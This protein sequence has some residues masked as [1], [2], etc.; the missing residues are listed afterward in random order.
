MPNQSVICSIFFDD[1]KTVLTHGPTPE[2]PFCTTY[3]LPGIERGAQGSRYQY[4]K[5][6]GTWQWTGYPLSRK[7]FNLL[8]IPDMFE[9]EYRGSGKYGVNPVYADTS[10]FK[11]VPPNGG[12]AWS[13]VNQWATNRMSSG[14]ARI[15][16]F[17]CA[18]DEPTETELKDATDSQIALCQ[19]IVADADDKWARNQ[20]ALVTEFP[21]KAAKWLGDTGHPWYAGQ[22]PVLTIQCPMCR[23]SIDSECVVCPHCTNVVDFTRF[24]Q[25]QE[26]SERAKTQLEK[27]RSKL[28]EEDRAA[29]APSTEELADSLGVKV[30]TPL[31]PGAPKTSAMGLRR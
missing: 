15:G 27:I 17:I 8:V 28:S 30:P 29:L 26:N 1:L 24:A 23:V 19:F 31:I 21:P 2:G 11:N 9:R 18:G 6:D 3:F 14:I 16:V 7:G 20:R 12:I 4:E 22:R 13:L 10:G 25:Y 5:K